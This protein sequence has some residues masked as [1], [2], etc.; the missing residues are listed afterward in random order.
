MSSPFLSMDIRITAFELSWLWSFDAKTVREGQIGVHD[1]DMTWFSLSTIS[2]LFLLSAI[3]PAGCWNCTCPSYHQLPLTIP[4]LYQTSEYVDCPCECLKW[5]RFHLWWWPHMVWNTMQ[6]FIY[7]GDRKKASF[8]KHIHYTFLFHAPAHT[9]SSHPLCVRHLHTTYNQ[10]QPLTTLSK[11]HHTSA[12]TTKTHTHTCMVNLHTH[13]NT[14]QL[15]SIKQK[16]AMEI[17][18]QSEV[19][20]TQRFTE[21]QLGLH[22]HSNHI[23]PIP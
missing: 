18:H 23:S 12:T 10:D 21:Q 6:G 15:A 19:Q 7:T 20:P 5:P 11:I 8:N 16:T 9:H 4:L 1:L 14:T 22:I 17:G 13:H 3:L 2:T